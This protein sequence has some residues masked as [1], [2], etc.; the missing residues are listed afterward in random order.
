MTLEIKSE[1]RNLTFGSGEPAISHE[2]A[3]NTLNEFLRAEQI[4]EMAE[5]IHVDSSFPGFEEDALQLAEELYKAGYKRQ[6]EG[7]W[8]SVDDRLP[9]KNTMVLG[10]IHTVYVDGSCWDTILVMELNSAGYFVP[11]NCSAIKDNSVTHWMPLPEPPKMK[12]GG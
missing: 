12:G 4:A 11:F 2:E 5:F 10:F 8:I 1:R 7:E 3:I 9:D 6:V